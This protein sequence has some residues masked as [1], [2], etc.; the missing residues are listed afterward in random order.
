MTNSM[1]SHTKP[2]LGY[3]IGA[4]YNSCLQVPH[5]L[6]ECQQY[7]PDEVLRHWSLQLEVLSLQ[8]I[9]CTTVIKPIGSGYKVSWCVERDN[10]S[11]LKI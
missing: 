5:R 1:Y 2:V 3:I 10:E 8:F 11:L 4:G 6:N 9:E 7:M